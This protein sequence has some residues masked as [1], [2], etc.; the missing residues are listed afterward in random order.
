MYQILS[1][2]QT[3]DKTNSNDYYSKINKNVG[4]K[5]AHNIHKYYSK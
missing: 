3:E 5:M 2:L 4:L 1:K